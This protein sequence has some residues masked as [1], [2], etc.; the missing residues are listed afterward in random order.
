MEKNRL[1]IIIS[2]AVAI[3]SSFLPWASLNAG[4]FG[5][6]S[7]NGL[8]G[9]GWFVIIF[10][11][12]A[13]VLACLNDVKSSLPKGFAIGIIVLGALSTIVTLIDLFGVNKYA[14]N[15]NGYG[16]SIGFGLILALIA[17]IAIVVT[18]LLA[19]S[20]GKITKGTFEELAES[21]KGFAQSV[22]RV[23]TSTIKTA[24]DEIKKETHEHTEGQADQPVE[25][26]KDPNQSEQ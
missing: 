1:F 13:I 18:G 12:V 24:V 17:S 8:R 4:A 16:V 20:G 25:A 6:Y 19:M 21:G 2:A 9:D 10:A 11:V 3:L 26:P 14:V 5:S 15:F 23:T 22:G 7:W